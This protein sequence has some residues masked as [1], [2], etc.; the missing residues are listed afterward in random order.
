MKYEKAVKKTR[1]Y[2]KRMLKLSLEVEKHSYGSPIYDSLMIDLFD[3][4][5]D[6]R[7]ARDKKNKKKM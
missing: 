1:K 6:Y 2:K 3:S 7:I 5:C 4:V